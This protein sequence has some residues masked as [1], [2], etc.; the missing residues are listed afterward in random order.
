MSVSGGSAW[1]FDDTRKEF[2]LHQFHP[3]QPDLNLRNKEVVAELQVG[4]SKWQLCSS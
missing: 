4:C 3:D 1:T 2:Y